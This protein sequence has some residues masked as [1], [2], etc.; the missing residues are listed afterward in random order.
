MDCSVGSLY[1]STLEKLKIGFLLDV[2]HSS[3]A[4]DLNVTVN[5]T[6]DNYEK[7]DL[8]HDNFAQLKLPLRRGIDLNVHGF[9]SPTA[10][11]FGERES[12]GCY[13]ERFNYTFKVLNAGPSRA[14]DTKVEI[15]IPKALVPY[16]YRLLN[17]VELQSS[18]GWCY[19][20]DSAREASDDCDVP[21]PY[22]IED[23]VFFFSKTLERHMYCMKTD[24]DCLKV[25]C[26]LGDMDIGKEATIQMEV[27]L[28]PAVLQISP[29]RQGIMVIETYATAT[30]RDDPYNIYI[31]GSP[32]AKVELEGHFNQKPTKGVEAFVTVVS[33]A[34]GVLIL[35]LLIYCL[36]MAGF[37]KREFKK[38]EEEIH[39]DSWDYVP[40]NDH[41]RALINSKQ[42]SPN[43]DFP[44]LS[45][46][47]EC[48]ST[49]GTQLTPDSQQAD[50]TLTTLNNPKR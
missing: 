6:C 7:E 5:A 32:F 19:I 23:L 45:H 1:M 41:K 44:H 2:N 48:T 50:N 18:V 13:T 20:N 39:R 9:V 38:K 21:K 28:N 16:P 43:G 47:L 24:G 42:E 8:L 4:G 27:E 10:F 26:K 34:I 49:T 29:G 25:V 46:V 31:K 14:L 37:F 36:W 22:F 12:S 15:D 35:A 3:N 17:I 11:I 33:L 40:K 30:P